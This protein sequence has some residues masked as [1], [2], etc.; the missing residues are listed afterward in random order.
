MEKV[1]FFKKCPICGEKLI[2]G[3]LG[4]FQVS[5][6]IKSKVKL[7]NGNRAIVGYMDNQFPVLFCEKCEIYFGEA[8]VE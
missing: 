2:N 8:K 3:E 1:D 5:F 4:P 6:F 7:E